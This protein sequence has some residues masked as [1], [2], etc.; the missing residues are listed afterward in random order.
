MKHAFAALLAALFLI[1]PARVA[2]IE[3]PAVFHD[4]MVYLKVSVNGAEPVWMNLDNGTSPSAISLDYARGLGLK[5]DKAAGWGTGIGHKPVEFFNTKADLTAGDSTR[6]IDFAASRLDGMLGPDGRPLAGVLGHS[7]LAGRIV[8]IDYP[9]NRVWFTS[10]L[11][12]CGCDLPMGEDFN[13]PTVPVTVA[14][15]RMTALIDSGGMYELLITPS[16]V[17]AAGLQA[18]A[19]AGRPRTSYGYA[20]AQTVH[21]GTAPDVI[22]GKIRRDNP[23]AVYGAFGTSPL[24]SQAALG[25]MFLK[26]YRVTLNYQARKVRLQ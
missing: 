14:G 13:I 19:E 8:V 12:P 10:R 22:V 20:G 16:G 4:G 21:V 9:R 5:L 23:S 25:A 26:D 2:D 24:K 17:R 6:R 18:Y 1:T 3:L 7:F 15:R 11:E